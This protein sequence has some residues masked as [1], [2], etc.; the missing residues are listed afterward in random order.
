MGTLVKVFASVCPLPQLTAK[1]ANDE[2]VEATFCS[3]REN[4]G[5]ESKEREIDA[6]GVGNKPQVLVNI[7]H[8]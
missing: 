7:W 1:C 5:L 4:L 8:R 6:V 3:N 2:G